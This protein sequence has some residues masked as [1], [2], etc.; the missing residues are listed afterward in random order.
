MYGVSGR[1][2]SPDEHFAVCPKSAGR[3]TTEIHGVEVDQ[4]SSTIF[5]HMV[6]GNVRFFLMISFLYLSSL[7]Q[8]KFISCEAIGWI[9]YVFLKRAS[10]RGWR[11]PLVT[12]SEN[13]QC[14]LNSTTVQ[15]VIA[16]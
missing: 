2:R 3:K 8:D 12:F 11:P 10:V 5:G 16:Q 14:R 13:D 15:V 9:F 6:A 4:S 7:M 1:F